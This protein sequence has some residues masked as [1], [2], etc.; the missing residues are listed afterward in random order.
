MAEKSLCSIEACDKPA[1]SK[2]WCRAHHARWLRLGDPLGSKPRTKKPFQSCSI[3][4]CGKKLKAHG[5]CSAHYSRFRKHGYP[6]SGGTDQKEPERFFTEVVLPYSEES[7]LI[8]P[9]AN[10][11]GYGIATINGKRSRVTRLACE[12]I[13]GPAPTSFH[14]AAH[15]CGNGGKGC[16]NPRHLRWA[17]PVENSKDRYKHGTMPIGE[18]N[19]TSK[20][21]RQD[22]VEIRGLANDVTYRMLAMIFRV[23]EDAIRQVVLRETWGWL[24]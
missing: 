7:C 10:T 14:Q 22:V 1:Y 24:K 6:L 5:W 9:Y 18:T 19:H 11:G 13:H 21:T 8:W 12:H 2:G 15:S 20:L 3:L 23:S 4:G 16:C 17:T